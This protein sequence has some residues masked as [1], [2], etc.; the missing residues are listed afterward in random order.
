MV[1]QWRRSRVNLAISHI[2]SCVG[3][4]GLVHLAS[5]TVGECFYFLSSATIQRLIIKFSMGWLKIKFS[6]NLSQ[7]Y[8]WKAPLG[9]ARVKIKI[10]ANRCA[11]PSGLVPVFWR[12]KQEVKRSFLQSDLFSTS[13][14]PFL[15]N[16]SKGHFVCYQNH[17]IVLGFEQLENAPTLEGDFW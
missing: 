14:S 17:P 11:S 4:L 3:F 12:C 1:L 9:V 15:P 5:A 16:K 13:N 7:I 8:L 10:F 6:V 2:I